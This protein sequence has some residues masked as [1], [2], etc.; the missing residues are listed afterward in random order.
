MNT[1]SGI[2]LPRSRRNVRSTRGE[3]WLEASWSTT[4]VIVNTS[5]VT[6]IIDAAIVAK[7]CSALVG[8]PS[9]K[10][11]AFVLLRCW[12]MMTVMTERTVAAAT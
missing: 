7:I 10:N 5:P 6:V 2:W 11:H 12:S 8:P 3:N 9:K 4:I 1:P